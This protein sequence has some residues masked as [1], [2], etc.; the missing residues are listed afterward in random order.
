[1]GRTI[2]STSDHRF[3]TTNGKWV[4]AK[5]LVANDTRLRVTADGPMTTPDMLED[6]ELELDYFGVF[7]LKTNPDRTLALA[8]VLG[9]IMT[10]GSVA[11]NRTG[12]VTMSC[13]VA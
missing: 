7:N 8:R 10:D 2:I 4:E 1:D 12:R 3:L 5:D 11:I 9:M 6:W 13:Y